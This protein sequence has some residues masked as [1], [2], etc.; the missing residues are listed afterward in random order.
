MATKTIK[1]L[2]VGIGFDV[3]KESM[4][5][6][7]GSIALIGKR[8][9]AMGGLLAG[10]FGA[11]TKAASDFAETVD[12]I[13]KFA[14]IMG[15][16]PGDV[17]AMGNALRTEGGTL[18]GMISQLRS[19]EELRAGLL[20]GDAGW[21]EAAGKAG[22]N[23]DSI[24]E[25]TNAIEAYIALADQFAD[26]SQDDRLNASKALGLDDASIRLLSQGEKH[27]RD[28]RDHFKEIRPITKEMAENAK[29]QNDEW[30][31]LTQNLG[32]FYDRVANEITGATSDALES[33]N[34][35][36]D[37]NRSGIK[38]FIDSE[39][40]SWK[41]IG[42]LL[43]GDNVGN[44]S[45][46]GITFDQMGDYLGSIVP[47]FGAAQS[48]TQPTQ[49]NTYRGT[50]IREVSPVTIQNDVHLDSQVIKR[51]VNRHNQEQASRAIEDLTSSAD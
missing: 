8:A 32:G 24:I 1:N 5:K 50:V 19:I 30:L 16:L 31:E 33:M 45:V 7:N 3:D 36:I 43:S 14:E 51:I 28:M 44:Y 40:N 48:A 13:A 15:L 27:V 18:D 49:G 47:D 2:L 4:G 23:Q 41:F 37:K 26:M 34:D 29:K 38:G 25:A 22:I 46:G 20:T 39:M 42:D 17:Q 21:L 11:S 6:A 35:W 12:P 9:L 10:A